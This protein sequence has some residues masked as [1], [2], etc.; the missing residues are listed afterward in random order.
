MKKHMN[1][2]VLI[3]DHDMMRRGLAA[4]FT[5]GGRWKVIG[6]ATNINETVALFEKLSASLSPLPDLVLL[7]I[8][9]GNE[10]GLDLIPF[11]KKHC[12]KNAP[13]V[14]VYSVY[15]DYAHIKA[16]IRAGAAGYISKSRGDAELETAMEAVLRGDSFIAPALM[17]KIVE[18]S[19]IMLAL[20]KRER[21][22]FEMVQRGISN[23]EI[24]EELKL[25][26]RTI[27]NNLSIIYDKT[28]VKNREELET[29]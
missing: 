1:T 22:I 10:W 2:V 21:Q 5:K 12:G 16:A 28:K 9:L 26:L 8:Q 24:A 25:S 19:D 23:R 18:V 15:E 29:L 14:L 17:E 11:L 20:T 6:E 27:E 7:D 3:E 4:Y 13:P